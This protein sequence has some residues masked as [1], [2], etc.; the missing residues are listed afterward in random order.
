VD[1]PADS[2]HNP[3]RFGVL[4]LPDAP[5]ETLFERWRQIEELG[6]DLLFAP[7]HA[8]H[9]RDSSLSW[10]DGLT[11]LGA[12]ALKTSR[13][14]IGALVANPLLHPPSVLAKKAAALDHLSRGRL[15]LGIG[16]GVEKFD[17]LETGNDYWP[18]RERAARY[19]EY[20]EVVDGVLRS[21]EEP[22]SF[23]GS[24]YRTKD[25]GLAPPT[26]QKPRPP[27]II[28]SRS[29]TGRALAVERGDCWNTYAL[30]GEGTIKE[31]VEKTRRRNEGLDERC[32]TAGRDPAALRRSLVMWSPLDPWAEPDALERIVEAFRPAGITEF[33]A[34]WPGDDRRELIERAAR[35]MARLRTS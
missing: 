4:D 10:F 7:D 30:T 6:F 23:S 26:P 5:F 8:R 11:V 1:S 13:I 31:I 24:Y 34:M 32:A 17:H 15:E 14:R 2:R 9:T 35:L 25:A 21:S 29:P 3:L 28:G 18:A 12:M 33:I 20:V 22:F 27:L 19:S 16:M